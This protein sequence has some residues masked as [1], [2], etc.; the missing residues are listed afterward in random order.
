MAD[1]AVVV[2]VAGWPRMRKPPA[3]LVPVVEAMTR[4]GARVVTVGDLT[5]WCGDEVAARRAVRVLREGGWLVPMRTR[6][7]WR[8]G[9]WEFRRT[10][11]FDE[12][13]ARLRTHP[14]TPAVI[15][16]RSVMEIHGWLKRPTEPTIA[17]PPGVLVPRCLGG[18]NLLRW[19]ARVPVGCVE[20]LPVW[21]AST[22]VAY[23]A[24][25]PARFGFE[26]AGEWLDAVCGAAA[27]E[28]IVSELEGLARSVWMK[29]AFIMWR[30][31]RPEAAAQLAALAPTGA[32]GPYKFGVPTGR[33]AGRTYGDFDVVDYIFE[34]HW[35]PPDSHFI[36]WEPHT[37]DGSSVSSSSQRWG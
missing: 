15:A 30:G 29:A 24:A 16:G 31:E 5:R 9:V 33:W 17:M 10:A 4:S 7:A 8:C 21:S 28:E 25:R 36:A 34:R 11:A 35:E 37:T 6:G 27:V 3:D 19:Q 22:L 13:L 23:M 1:S 26:D 32:R 14:E 12:L 2:D 18:L 20:G